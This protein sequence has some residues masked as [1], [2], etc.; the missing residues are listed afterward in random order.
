MTPLFNPFDFLR[1]TLAI[2]RMM[3]EAQQVIMLRMAGMAGVWQMGPAE[4][5]RMM[6]EKVEAM[7]ESAQAVYASGMAGDTLSEMAMAGIAPLRDRT[8]A[9]AKR[10]ISKAGGGAA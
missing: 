9:N 8:R 1:P 5:Q 7:T 2:S 10:L 6:D 3:V 4:N